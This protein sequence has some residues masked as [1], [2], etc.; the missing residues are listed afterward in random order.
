VKGSSA[1][2]FFALRLFDFPVLE[3]VSK[4]HSEFSLPFSISLSA[5]L[6][7]PS[8]YTHASKT[9]QKGPITAVFALSN[10]IFLLYSVIFIIYTCVESHSIEIDP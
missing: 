5:F 6:A 2:L 3:D 1:L 4:Q 7:A 10:F 9:T 8:V